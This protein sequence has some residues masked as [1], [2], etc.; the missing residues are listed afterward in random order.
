MWKKYLLKMEDA[1][2]TVEKAIRIS[3]PKHKPPKLDKQ[4]RLTLIRESCICGDSR[5]KTLMRELAYFDPK[6]VGY[7]RIPKDYELRKSSSAELIE[8]NSLRRN[9]WFHYLPD[10]ARE[11]VENNPRRRNSVALIHFHPSIVAHYRREANLDKFPKVVSGLLA[12]E[13]G[14]SEDDLVPKSSGSEPEY[15]CVPNHSLDKVKEE[16]DRLKL[17]RSSPEENWGVAA[18][19]SRSDGSSSEELYKPYAEQYLIGDD[20]ELKTCAQYMAIIKDM[21]Q[22]E[23]LHLKKI[24]HLE[25]RSAE[26]RNIEKEYQL[27]KVA[28]NDT[29]VSRNTISNDAWHQQHPEAAMYLFGFPTW[30]DTKTYIADQFNVFHDTN[31]IMEDGRVINVAS[32]L[33]AFEEY[34]ATKMHFHKSFELKFLAML[35][36]KAESTIGRCVKRRADAWKGTGVHQPRRPNLQP[37]PTSGGMPMTVNTSHMRLAPEGMHGWTIRS[38]DVPI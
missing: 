12:I 37:I 32:P 5:C 31:K 11:F 30:E 14:F 6:R 2:R 13:A 36:G 24:H 25:Q 16:V 26:L 17:L 3:K 20:L 10:A 9:R 29:Y 1:G 7:V 22:R 34:L 15:I 21:Q 38:A 35:W 4:V 19:A 23:G 28:C 18:Q 27:L 33:T 8:R